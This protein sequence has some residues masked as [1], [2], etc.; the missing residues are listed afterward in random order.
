MASRGTH[1]V[2][3]GHAVGSS[4]GIHMIRSASECLALSSAWRSAYLPSSRTASS[5]RRRL[6]AI[7]LTA[8]PASLATPYCTIDVLLPSGA[9]YG[10][11]GGLPM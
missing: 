3:Q 11:R 9:S 4:S 1:A 5:R 8:P 2:A 7:Q 6:P 10:A